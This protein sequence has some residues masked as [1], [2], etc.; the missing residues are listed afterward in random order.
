MPPRVDRRR[1]PLA[2]RGGHEP[3]AG[4][5]R[6]AADRLVGGQ[7]GR[8]V[9]GDDRPPGGAAGA[10]HAGLGR[11][12]AADRAVGAVGGDH[13]VGL[14]GV[15]AVADRRPLARRRRAPWR[16]VDPG[17]DLDPVAEAGD[18]RV[19][20]VLPV[21]HHRHPVGRAWAGAAPASARPG[22][23]PRRR[24][25]GWRW[26]PGRRR[27]R[28]RAARGRRWARAPAA[29]GSAADPV[30]AFQQ[31]DLPAGAGQRAGHRQAADARRR[32][33]PRVRIGRPRSA[34]P[35]GGSRAVASARSRARR[36]GRRRPPARRRPTR[37]R[38]LPVGRRLGRRRPVAVVGRSAARRR[39]PGTRRTAPRS[40]TR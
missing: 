32:P 13:Q 27:G 23:G 15:P 25:A 12:L 24:A 2:E 10:D 17:T 3:V 40:T 29:V 16:T 6:L 39:C 33:P 31:G 22:G 34:V 20:Q 35:V 8:P 11:E 30:G 5:E 28:G 26:R 18:Q 9:P 38:R 7:L 1:A 21:H 37:G 14:E 4:A 19:V 36:A